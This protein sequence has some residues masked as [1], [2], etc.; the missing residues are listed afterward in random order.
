MDNPTGGDSGTPTKKSKSQPAKYKQM[1]AKPD[2]STLITEHSDG[3]IGPWGNP[4]K[5]GTPQSYR[6]AA[7]GLG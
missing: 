3:K 6:R 1:V 7:A 5:Q 4:I 2:T